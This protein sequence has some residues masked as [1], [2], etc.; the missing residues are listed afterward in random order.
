MIGL[1][2]Y[3]IN[4]NISGNKLAEELN[5]SPTATWNWF[6][7]NKVPDKYH[8]LIV[9]KFN[10]DK[11]YINKIVNN[12][13][14]YNPKKNEFNDYKIFEDDR[15]EF[16]TKN[17]KGESFTVKVDKDIL[18]RLIEFN[19][20]WNASYHKNPDAYYIKT[21]Y[22]KKT[23]YLHRWIVNA[24][25][26]TYVDHKNHDTLDNI[27]INLRVTT[28]R[29]NSANRERA[30]KNSGTGHRNVNYGYNQKEYWVQFMRKGE[31][32]K[33][34]FPLDKFKE[35]C[36]FADIKRVEIFGEYAGNS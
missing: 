9:D 10:I 19:H 21:T 26:N 28:A 6:I 8:D 25:K 17:N 35:A 20:S 16:Y 32:F 13:N 4:N 5:L 11:K 27:K 34:V 15:C 2:E 31:R 22:N 7:K 33:W 23:I 24:D 29:N 18:E 12:I 1:Q 36:D 14:T 30:N 3:C